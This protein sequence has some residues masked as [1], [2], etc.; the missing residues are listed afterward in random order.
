MRALEVCFNM[1]T[2][3]FVNVTFVIRILRQVSYIVILKS[4]HTFLHMEQYTN[5]EIS[6]SNSNLKV[7]Q[8]IMDGNAYFS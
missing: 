1:T 5:C 6:N 3:K 4:V 7:L 2:S 8:F